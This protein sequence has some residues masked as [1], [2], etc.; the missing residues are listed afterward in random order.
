MTLADLK[1]FGDL[2]VKYAAL[3]HQDRYWWLLRQLISNRRWNNECVQFWCE[4]QTPQFKTLLCLPSVALQAIFNFLDNESLIIWKQV[5]RFVNMDYD[6]HDRDYF[7]ILVSTAL[8]GCQKCPLFMLLQILG[9]KQFIY[10]LLFDGYVVKTPLAVAL[11]NVITQ[12]TNNTPLELTLAMKTLN[13]IFNDGVFINLGDFLSY[14][15]AFNVAQCCRLFYDK[16]FNVTYARNVFKYHTLT[17]DD[18]K[19][20]KWIDKKSDWF[21]WYGIQNLHWNVSYD[22]MIKTTM[23]YLRP[24]NLRKYC[25]S[26][27]KIS[28]IPDNLRMV[29]FEYDTSQ[30]KHI[31][32]EYYKFWCNVQRRM[33]HNQLE[34]FVVNNDVINI[35]GNIMF[36]V[37]ILWRKSLI[38]AKYIRAQ[39]LVHKGTN[40]LFHECSL[41]WNFGVPT[42]FDPVFQLDLNK[43]FYW[44][45]SSS[46]DWQGLDFLLN[47]GCMYSVCMKSIVINVELFTAARRSFIRL[48]KSLAIKNACVNQCDFK[49]FFHCKTDDYLQYKLQNKCLHDTIED[50][51]CKWTIKYR[52]TVINNSSIKGFGFGFFIDGK[53]PAGYYFDLKQCK[54]KKI[55]VQH[56]IKF[57]EALF[58]NGASTTFGLTDVQNEWNTF[59]NEIYNE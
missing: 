21:L 59:C 47:I 4:K 18:N 14:T 57:H 30:L 50:L 41:E 7:G 10:R 32:Y 42:F 40:F 36:A 26:Y 58:K 38:S 43:R 3:F 45:H 46:T 49:F 1:I 34:M 35:F 48:L 56:H 24:T 31:S 33:P 6:F 12:N 53:T 16:T 17:V 28:C 5:S 25:S 22:V 23:P 55:L 37:S 19:A 9:D 11:I 27:W 20:L 54:C 2:I 44:Y 15:E 13:R 39:Q 51:L 29:T 8:I 52:E